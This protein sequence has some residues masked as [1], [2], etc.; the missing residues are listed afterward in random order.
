MRDTAKPDP[1]TLAA[2]QRSLDRVFERSRGIMATEPTWQASL[3]QSLRACYA[4]MCTHPD[5]LRLHFIAAA[6]DPAVQSTR[7]RHRDRLLGLLHDARE[8]APPPLHAELL[9]SMIHAAMRTQISA[10][11]S[12]P[13]LDTAEQTFASLLFHYDVPPQAHTAEHG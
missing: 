6:G 5:A 7:T 13:D 8:D 10:H 11:K 4:E 1:R 12:P 9:L 2:Y 3:Y